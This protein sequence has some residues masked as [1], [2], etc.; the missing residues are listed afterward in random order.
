VRIKAIFFPQKS[1]VFV[2]SMFFRLKKGRKF[3]LKKKTDPW[4]EKVAHLWVRGQSEPT[5]DKCF[6]SIGSLLGLNCG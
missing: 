5:T 4:G 3:S 6:S 2:E 1:F